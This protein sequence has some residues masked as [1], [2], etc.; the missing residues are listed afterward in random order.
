MTLR[1]SRHQIA[2]VLL[3][4]LSLVRGMIYTAVIP[5]WQ[6]P[7]EFKHFEY[8][9]LLHQKQ[10]P[11]TAEDT[12]IPLQ[13]E[14]IGSML[15]HDYWEFGRA[16]YPFD[17]KHPP[18]SFSEI[19]WP[20][21][22]YWLFQP[23]LYYL[24]GVSFMSLV[25]Q[26]DIDLQLYV[27]RLVSVVL[28][29]LVVFMAFLTA[30]EL[31]P[32]DSFMIIG[33]PAFVT[34]LPMHSFISSAVNND[35]L[36]E[37]FVSAIVLTLTM[38]FKNGLSLQK[39]ILISLLMALGLF[40]KRTAVAAVPL[41]VTGIFLYAWE[42]RSRIS[43]YL[44]RR[45]V[46]RVAL[47]S[48]IIGITLVVTFRSKWEA[49]W[50]GILPKVR[51]YFILIPGADF[52]ELFS[53]KGVNLLIHYVKT[54][55]E[56]FWARFGWMNVHLD[57]IWYLAVAL[58]SAAAM[59]GAGLFI[60]RGLRKGV[61]FAPWQKR[62]LLLFVLSVFSV[63]A[64]AMFYGIRVWAHFQN[65]QPEISAVPPQGRYL[66]VVIIPIATLFI[67][68]LRELVRVR[69]RR[70]WLVFCIGSLILF[71]TVSLIHYIIPFFYR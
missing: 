2:L 29:T 33:I 64:I 71:D 12:S 52:S 5:P 6:T 21:D 57:S 23:P 39:I 42:Q 65:V 62:C 69:Y 19:I 32:D 14:I 25:D 28:G 18:Q 49:L 56:S 61:T 22:P 54:L 55:F 37:F 67:L 7:D 63:V 43:S 53:Q 4:A 51:P 60:I 3:L 44:N 66:F 36:A 31:F 13:R 50:I 17:P 24:L 1:P 70:L 10:R 38:V 40:T 27:V 34:F 15:E 41:V 45:T 30:T 48:L 46:V 20:L 11:L 47:S 9:K 8:I 35:N 26:N 58:V 59:G 16:T 68:G